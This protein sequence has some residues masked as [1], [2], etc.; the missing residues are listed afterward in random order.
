[1]S[2]SLP[3][4]RRAMTFF[5][6][7]SSQVDYV[8]QLLIEQSLGEGRLVC[9]VGIDGKATVYTVDTTDGPVLR[10]IFIDQSIQCK[11]RTQHLVDGVWLS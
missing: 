6:I 7:P 3:E 8:M 2:G 9:D 10:K 4:K 1:M 11:E 5:V